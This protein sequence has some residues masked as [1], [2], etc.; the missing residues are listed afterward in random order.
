MKQR[1]TLWFP[2]PTK[3]PKGTAC[4][5]SHFKPDC[6]PEL[7]IVVSMQKIYHC[8]MKCSFP[9]STCLKLEKCLEH[10][11]DFLQVHWLAV[12]QCNV[13]KYDSYVQ[14]QHKGPFAQLKK[15]PK[16]CHYIKYTW[17]H[18]QVICKLHFWIL[19][20]GVSGALFHHI[21]PQDILHLKNCVWAQFCFTRRCVMWKKLFRTNG[22]V[23]VFLF[24]M[25]S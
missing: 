10:W 13:L 9:A 12:L 16:F 22:F 19:S 15:C 14:M 2:Q 6:S 4:L 20:A 21:L 3:L 11:G 8:S 23:L 1:A 18:K 17:Q 7:M 25:S 5:S 24:P